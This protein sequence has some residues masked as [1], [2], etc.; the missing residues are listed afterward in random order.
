MSDNKNLINKIL[1]ISLG[2]SVLVVIAGAL[3]IA[4][5]PTDFLKDYVSSNELKEVEFET[6][7]LGTL[8]DEY[9]A[10][11]EDFCLE[12]TPN[13]IAPRFTQTITQLRTV[14]LD[15]VDR[16]RTITPQSMDIAKQQF[17]FLVHDQPKPFPDV[18]TVRFID[19][20]GQYSSVAIYSRTEIG[21]TKKGVNEKR[22]SRWLALLSK[23]E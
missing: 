17:T 13:I 10:C 12:A 4:F 8:E 11:P 14:L 23:N 16:D 18:V 7:K 22:V 15:Y 3:F 6:L 1:T 9:L 19:L 5:G 21:K 2:L 20:Y